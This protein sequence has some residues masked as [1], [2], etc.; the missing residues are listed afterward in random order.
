[1]G[2]T[3]LEEIN[4]QKTIEEFASQYAVHANQTSIWKK[5]LLDAAHFAFSNILATVQIRIRVV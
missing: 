4:G 3:S 2:P 1:L 5:Q